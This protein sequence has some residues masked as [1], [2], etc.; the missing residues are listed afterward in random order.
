M[1][2]F[3]LRPTVDGLPQE[4]AQST[5][6]HRSRASALYG[7]LDP[8]VQDA[9]QP[10]AEIRSLI[11]RHTRPGEVSSPFAGVKLIAQ[12]APTLPRNAVHRPALALVAQGSKRTAVGGKLF[13][14]GAGDYLVLPVELPV[15]GQVIEASARKPYLAFVLDLNPEAIAALMLATG[16]EKRTA[17][18][19]AGMV[20][21]RMPLELLDPIVR[22]LR[23]LDHPEDVDILRPM[24]ER[25]ILWRLLTGEQSAIV[26]QIG[27]A[28]SHLSRINLVLGKIRAQYAEPLRVD[29]LAR[30]ASMSVA[31][32]HRHFRSV[33]AMSPLQFQKQVRL[34]EARARL[35]SSSKDVAA[36]GFEV[37]YDSPS[38]FSREYS[39]FFGVPPG[40]DM[41]RLRAT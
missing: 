38:Q 36:V 21:S 22:Y 33:M 1:R 13:E 14:Y 40:K 24:L 4:L 6:R 23:L 7:L 35:L 16:M 32:F 28:E 5:H 27:F 19:P 12:T 30:T 3:N 31:T 41:R 10:L 2:P 18:S 37:G 9:M 11:S 25:E 26:R 29:D 34:H 8:S 20:G 15:V 39:R 17:L